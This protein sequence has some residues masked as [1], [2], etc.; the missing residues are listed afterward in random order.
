MIGKAR[1]KNVG[2][3][4][5]RKRKKR[6]LPARCHSVFTEYPCVHGCELDQGHEGKHCCP[7]AQEWDDEESDDE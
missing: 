5:P 3:Y 4:D 6:E 2:G 7:C 1:A